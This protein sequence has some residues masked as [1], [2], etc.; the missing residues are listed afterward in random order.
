MIS[1]SAYRQAIRDRARTL[2]VATT[3][4]TTLATTTTTYTRSSGSFLT[5]G[6]A[7]GM[8]VTASGFAAANN[9]VALITGLTATVMTVRRTSPLVTSAAASGRTIAAGLPSKR[10]WENVEFQPVAEWPYVEEQYIPGPTT[11]T[12]IGPLAELELTPMYVLLVNVPSN[13]SVEA[14]TKYADELLGHFAP[15]TTIT[16]S[17]GDV[18]RVRGDTGPFPAQLRQGNPGYA[19]VPVTIPFRLRT[20]NPI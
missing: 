4:A 6:F 8:E 20:N 9:G 10:A 17:N 15:G 1:H 7:V 19:V 14:A 11:R 16:A 18:L 2:S 5:D 13:S 3:G 12:T